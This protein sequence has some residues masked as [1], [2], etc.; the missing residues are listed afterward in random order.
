MVPL[1]IF[2]S[3]TT[4]TYV[5]DPVSKQ[6]INRNVASHPKK[7]QEDK[8]HWKNIKY[9]KNNGMSIAGQMENAYKRQEIFVAIKRD[10]EAIGLTQDDDI[11]ISKYF[12]IK[13][14]KKDVEEALH[15]AILY[16]MKMDSFMTR[17]YLPKLE[18]LMG[19]FGPIVAYLNK[20][21]PD[22]MKQVFNKYIKGHSNVLEMILENDLNF[23]A[24][25]RMIQKYLEGIGSS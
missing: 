19:K 6:T 7:N 22:K 18:R 16:C 12:G 2:L 15:M 20:H 11:I 25:E 17:K 10:A 14:L 23:D 3:L 4:L 13:G 1:C 24:G 8:G 9:D 5:G 21:E